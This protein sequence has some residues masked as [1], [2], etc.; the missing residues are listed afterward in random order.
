MVPVAED[1]DFDVGGGLETV[2][3]LG[4]DSDTVID[5]FNQ[6]RAFT[7]DIVSKVATYSGYSDLRALRDKRKHALLTTKRSY[8]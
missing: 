6:V 5:L 7:L 1:P 3:L 2:W 4:T 8:L